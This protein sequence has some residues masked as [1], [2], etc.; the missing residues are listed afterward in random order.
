MRVEKVHP[1][2]DSLA[3]E[4]A[5]ATRF[6]RDV[7]SFYETEDD[8]PKWIGRLRERDSVDVF[9]ATEVDRVVGWLTLFSFPEG[10]AIANPIRGAAAGWPSVAKE[11]D[12]SKVG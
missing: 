10:Y 3:L 9:L 8:V 4:S 12:E 5:A 7:S 1:A 11:S 2:A 6:V